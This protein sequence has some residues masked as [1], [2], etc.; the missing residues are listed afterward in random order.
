ML[1]GTLYF[2]ITGNTAVR[3]RNKVQAQAYPFAGAEVHFIDVGQGDSTLL[4]QGSS[5]VLIDG[6]ESGN[7]DMLVEYLLSHGVE[8]LDLL[9][10]THDHSDHTGGLAKVLETFSVAETMLFTDPA[11]EPDAADQI[12]QQAL[13]ENG[14]KTFFLSPGNAFSIAEM[15]LTVLAPYFAKEDENEESIVLRVEYGTTSFLFTGD[16]TA[17]TEKTLLGADL[18]LDCDVLKVGH[19][20]SAT[21]STQRFLHAVTP[22]YAVIS[23]GADNPYGHPAGETLT[24][25]QQSQCEVFRTDRDGTVVLCSDGTAIHKK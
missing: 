8:K 13:E 16:A 15:K 3:P 21:S 10:A 12:F 25:L 6:G 7:G 4:L 19:H 1:L 2:F 11:E 9:V 17:D 22:A 24:R 23:C 14:T 20:G 5:A 18:S